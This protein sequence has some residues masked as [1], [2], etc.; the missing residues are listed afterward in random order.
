MLGNIYQIYFLLIIFTKYHTL[1]E[2]IIPERPNLRLTLYR[3][4]LSFE[5]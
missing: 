3:C 5:V 4:P 2:S 1:S